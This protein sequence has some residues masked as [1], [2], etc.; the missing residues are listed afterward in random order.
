MK[1]AKKKLMEQEMSVLKKV[2][3]IAIE[4]DSRILAN[5]I[6]QEIENYEAWLDDL[7]NEQEG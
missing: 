3:T 7:N 2:L 1:D 5:A 4:N 6:S